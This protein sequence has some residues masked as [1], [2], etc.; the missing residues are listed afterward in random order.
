MLL[1]ETGIEILCDSL[2]VNGKGGLHLGTEI[3]YVC[4]FVKIK[5]NAVNFL[6]DNLCIGI[7]VFN[8][9]KV[10]FLVGTHRHHP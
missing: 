6:I 3:D 8:K 5:C 4:L 2:G 7:V 1:L 10:A 9:H